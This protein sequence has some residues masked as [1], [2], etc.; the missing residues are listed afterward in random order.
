M[1]ERTADGLRQCISDL[2]TENT[3]LRDQLA[4]ALET[5]TTKSEPASLGSCSEFS[6]GKSAGSCSSCGDTAVTRG[7]SGVWSVADSEELEC[8]VKLLGEDSGAVQQL[9]ARLARAEESCGL[10]VAACYISWAMHHARSGPRPRRA[11]TLL[12]DDALDTECR[13]TSEV[14][15]DV[16]DADLT[17]ALELRDQLQ[18]EV[19]QLQQLRDQL[20]RELSQLEVARQQLGE[21]EES[22]RLV[23]RLEERVAGLTG[24]ATT[25]RQ[26]A[27]A[28]HAELDTLRARDLGSRAHAEQLQRVIADI[29]QELGN[30]DFI[31]QSRAQAWSLREKIRYLVD[32]ESK[33]SESVSKHEERETAFRATLAE[34]DIIMT[35]IEN[36]YKTRLAD[37][38][39]ERGHLRG[40]LT[41]ASH[42]ADFI[43][44]HLP[45]TAADQTRDLVEKLFE[46]EKSELA[47]MDKIFKLENTINQL[48]QKANDKEILKNELNDSIKDQEETFAQIQNLRKENKELLD[49]IVHKKEVEFRCAELQQT[50]GYLRARVEELEL[51][52]AGLREALAGL[53]ARAG[54]RERRLGEEVRRLR[55]EVTCH[56]PAPT[57]DEGGQTGENLRLECDAVK[58]KLRELTAQLEEK[59]KQF[60]DTEASLR[61][62]V[63]SD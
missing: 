36:D 20:G 2:E 31:S 48:S 1:L 47:F 4:S 57:C 53:E 30:A 33:Y 63:G 32:S 25:A 21:A 46:K 34:A 51:A 58:E 10:L 44:Q 6:G 38:E 52:E 49:E 8:E 26:E 29:E 42:A 59:C 7:S 16:T 56:V 62:E 60:Q 45:A 18:G 5:A 22:R 24:E 61:T 3:E 14:R 37:L 13:D 43:R 40:Q 35:N 55:E 17:P 23:T 19:T 54:A 27:A 41:H 28:L 15:G 9:Q 39:A 50:E 11:V 12:S